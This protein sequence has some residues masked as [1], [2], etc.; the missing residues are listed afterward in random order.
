MPLVSRL[1]LGTHLPGKLCFPMLTSM[2]HATID[3]RS[4][5]FGEHTACRL[6]A[7]P[8]LLDAARAQL[9]RWRAHG[10]PNVQAT[11]QEWQTTLDA[12]LKATVAVLV[13]AEERHV[14]LRQ[15]AP[16]RRGDFH[17]PGGT[18]RHPAEVRRLMPFPCPQRE[19]VRPG[20][21]T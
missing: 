10:A 18:P 8:G 17:P 12:G 3:E 7:Q 4:L 16:L 5:A 19:L 1:R 6:R 15:S 11:F 13:G 2:S 20:M 21:V 9:A 14:R